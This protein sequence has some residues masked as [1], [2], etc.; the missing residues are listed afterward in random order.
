MREFFIALTPTGPLR[1]GDVKATGSYLDTITYIPGSVLRGTLA[2]WLLIKGE[3]HRIVPVVRKTRFGNLFPSLYGGVYSLPFPM[4]A[5]ECKAEGG[6]LGVPRSAEYRKKE[7]HG[8]S[9]GLLVALAYNELERMGASFPVPMTLRCRRC[10]QRLERAIGFY[11]KLDYGWVKVD[12]EKLEQTKVSLS[13]FRRSSKEGML[14]RVLALRPK[15]SFVGR[16]WLEEEEDLKLLQEA[17]EKIGVGALTTRGFG[18][19]TL[20]QVDIDFPSSEKRLKQFNDKLKEV[21]KDLADLAKQAGNSVP[22]EPKHTYFSVDLVSPAILLD[23]QGLP[24]L[25]LHLQLDGEWLEPVFWAT[26]PTFVGGWSTAW[27]LPKPTALGAAMGSV[28]VFRTEKTLDEITPQL[29]LLE[30][31]GVGDRKDEGFGEVLIC[32]PF[33]TEVRPV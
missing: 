9:D 18:R 17:V 13:R 31:R 15:G 7:G 2:E 12:L 32:H 4:T 22:E 28:Y 5:L 23:K 24:T 21:W 25:K 10:K 20:K 8:I 16:V 11:A 19:A 27:G 29:E 33:H 26:R 1:V 6:F 30:A 14:Y 3:A